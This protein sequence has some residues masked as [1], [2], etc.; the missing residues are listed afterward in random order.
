M[1]FDLAAAGLADLFGFGLADLG[2]GAIDAG[3]IGAADIGA[4]VAADL[5]AGAAGADVA[6]GTVADIGAGAATDIGAGAADI[7]AAT[8]AG[9]GAADVSGALAG[10]G[11]DLAG[12]ITPT[13]FDVA[14]A[15]DLGTNIGGSTAADALAGA[16]ATDAGLT[17]QTAAGGL[18]G[19][20]GAGAVGPSAA[21]VADAGTIAPDVIAAGNDPNIA[22]ATG[23]L[24]MPPPTNVSGP[25]TAASLAGGTPGATADAAAGMPP[26]GDLAASP[27]GGVTAGLSSVLNSPWTQAASLAL[28]LGML[29]YNLIKGPP[30]IPPQANAAI[31]NAQTNAEPLISAATQNVPLYNAT[32]ATDLNLANNFQISPAQAASIKTWQQDQY[33]QL[34]QQIANRGNSNPMQSSDWIQGKNQI[35][36]Q[37]L[38]MQTQMVN[39]LI[40][41]AFQ[42][43][44]AA[45][46]GISTAGNITNQV[47]SL[48]MQAANLQVQQDAAF[49]Q[50]VSAALQSF[51]LLAAF[52][53]KFG[54]KTANA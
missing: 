7:G 37:A 8:G 12:T 39:Q 29:G 38:S 28:P 2:A 34:I 21:P 35:D 31:A 11:A 45:N 53:G 3:A 17:G 40:S 13:A 20:L 9:T 14:A 23:A 16:G 46:A 44:T 54:S 5:G 52:S 6:A 22:A 1:G 32:A 24:D 49:N 10:A 25:S 41:T 48:L 50:S 30:S 19:G 47:D 51:G 4:G 18:T 36:Q 43:S 26:S 27:S 42:A 33:N 15:G